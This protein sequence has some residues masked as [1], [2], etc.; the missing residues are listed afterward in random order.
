MTYSSTG[1]TGQQRGE[2]DTK[3]SFLAA[4]DAL[5]P[6]LTLLASLFALALGPVLVQFGRVGPQAAAFL[7]GFTFI[8]IAGLLGFNIL[9]A[10]VETGGWFAWPCL[11]L[12][13]A[14]PALLES[15]LHH[16]ARQAHAAI[17]VLGI[18]GLAAHSL[19]DGVALALP[20]AGEAGHGHD[21]DLALAVVL[22]RFPVGLAVWFLLA[23][24]KG[25][26]TALLGLAAMMLATVGGFLAGGAWSVLLTTPALAWFQAFVAG[27][28]LHVIIYEPGH[29]DRG[30]EVVAKWPDRFGLLCGLALLYLYL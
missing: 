30:R 5:S 26:R 2:R 24:S 27:S 11:L 29:H 25:L 6:T 8:S 20:G 4:A 10:A 14:F 13:L 16:F 12:G 18:A 1:L 22:H 21:G 15:Q 7:G 28:I 3:R 23:G 9:P 19:V 17:L